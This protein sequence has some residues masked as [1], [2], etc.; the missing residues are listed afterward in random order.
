M[1]IVASIAVLFLLVVAWEKRRFEAQLAKYFENRAARSDDQFVGAFFANSDV[2]SSIPIK[3]RQLWSSVIG[4]DMRC[5]E[6]TDN[7]LELAPD[8]DVCDLLWRIEKEFHLPHVTLDRAI[9]GTFASIV[10]YVAR[11]LNR[12]PVS[13]K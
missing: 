7:V 12:M 9:D 8:L 11:R 3:M 4:A 5:L 10:A 1:L 6:P 2:S 13:D